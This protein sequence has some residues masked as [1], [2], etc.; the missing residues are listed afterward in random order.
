[1]NIRISAKMTAPKRFPIPVTVVM[2]E[3]NSAIKSLT[4]FSALSM[5][6]L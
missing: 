2:T 3:L 6:L 1:M 5:S 4:H